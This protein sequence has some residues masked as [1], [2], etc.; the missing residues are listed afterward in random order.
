MLL[1]DAFVLRDREALIR[2]FEP[3]AVLC[4]AAGDPLARGLEEIAQVVISLWDHKRTYVADPRRVLQ[5]RRTALVLSKEGINVVR[6][7]HSGIWRFSISCLEF[8]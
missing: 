6:R 5:T 3:R 8:E 1:E 2:L 4:T 7:D